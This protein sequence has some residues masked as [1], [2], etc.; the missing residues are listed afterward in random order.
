MALDFKLKDVGHNIIVKFIQAY[1]PEAKKKYY[2]KPV[3]QPILDLHAV[4]SKAEVYNINTSPNVIEKGLTAALELIFYLIADGYI[5]RTPLFSI[6]I[7]IPGEYD[8]S[9]THLPDGIHP[10]VRL[11][12]S[13]ELREYVKDSVHVT[14]DGIEDINGFIATATDDATG[15]TDETVTPDNMLIIR[16]TGLKIDSDALHATEVGCFFHSDAAGD[17]PARI[18]A[19][20]EPHTLRVITPTGLVKGV[21]YSIVIRTQSSVRNSTHTLKNVREMTSEF[22]LK[23]Q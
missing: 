1:L 6:G 14:F 5:I 2:A 20:N 4:A 21:N 18:I 9:E 3:F 15:L 8:G 17:T 13:P 19:L 7:R 23:A 22:T 16:G 12:V 10:E 11:T